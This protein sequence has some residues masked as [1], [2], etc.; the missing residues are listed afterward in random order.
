MSEAEK[1]LLQRNIIAG[2]PGSEES[3]TLAQ[4]QQA[5]DA[6]D[7]IDAEKLRQHLILFLEEIVPVAEEVSV[8]LAIH[9]DDPPYAILGLPRV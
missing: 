5:L 8:N 6:Y 2:L 4:F 7:G 3:F 1:Q 9:P